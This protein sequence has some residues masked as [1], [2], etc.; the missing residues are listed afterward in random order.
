MKIEAYL[1]VV[2][3]EMTVRSIDKE[4]ALQEATAK[5]TKAPIAASG[6]GRWWNW[7]T[8]RVSLDAD[9]PSEGVNQM[10]LRYRPIFPIIKS[11]IGSA[12]DAYL[13]LVTEYGSD[14]EPRCLCLSAE[15][16]GR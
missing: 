5:E 2:A 12:C 4:A 10:L 8:R 9:N 1:R 3:N 16:I 11:R 14:E 6:R 13:Q 7:S 15:T